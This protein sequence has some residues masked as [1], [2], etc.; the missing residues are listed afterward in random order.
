K[1]P[2]DAILVTGD[3]TDAGRSAEWAELLD[4]LS[5]YPQLAD[6]LLFLPGNHDLNVADRA[7]PARLELP[8]SPNRRLR[9]LRALSFF[10]TTQGQR[11]RVID[12]AKRELGGC[13]ADTVQPHLA[14]VMM[15]ANTGT[16]R[17]ST[18][19]TNLWKDS[20]PMVV[21]PD[22]ETG[23]GIILLNSNVETQ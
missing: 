2:L 18:V 23:L 12:Y 16:P 5:P 17:L 13:L 19:L 6:R 22:S 7:N 1:N 21:P 15:F 14:E 4:A 9:Q 8:T 3:M 20:F 11:V 10:C